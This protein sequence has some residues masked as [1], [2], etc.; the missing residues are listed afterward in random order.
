MA[1]DHYEYLVM[2]FGLTNILAVF[3]A[4]DNDVLRDTLNWFIFVYLDDILVFS[5]STQEHVFNFRQVL[6][7]LQ[8][9]IPSLHH[10]LSGLHHL[11][12]ECT[13]GSR[14]RESGGGLAPAYVQGAAATFP[15]IRQLLSPIYPE[16]Q[17]PGFPTA[18]TSPNV[19]FTW[20]PAADQAF[21]DLKHHFTTASVLVH[22][23]P[24]RQFVVEA[25]ASDVPTA[26]TPQRGSMM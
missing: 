14:K 9:R 16:L 17:Q 10:P 25:N 18:I 24:S 7:R 8:M 21:R 26:S 2:P 13:D 22:P 23:D 3:Q 4:L 5:R 19:P 6:Q 12:R 20:S 15:G 11:C 1:S